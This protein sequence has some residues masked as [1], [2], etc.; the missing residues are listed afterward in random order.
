MQ[1][2]TTYQKIADHL[3]GLFHGCEQNWSTN[4]MAINK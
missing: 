3:F 1:E 2:K 4:E